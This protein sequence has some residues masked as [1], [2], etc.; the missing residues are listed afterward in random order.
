MR[1][2]YGFCY[3][4]TTFMDMTFGDAFM[5]CFPESCQMLPRP[6]S[7]NCIDIVMGAAPSNAVASYCR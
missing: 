5:A 2:A 3:Q 1:C 4:A 6:Q 7:T